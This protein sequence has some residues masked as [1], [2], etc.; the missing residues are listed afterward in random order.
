MNLNRYRYYECYRELCINDVECT[1]EYDQ[2]ATLNKFVAACATTQLANP[3]SSIWKP[4][5][6]QHGMKRF[7]LIGTR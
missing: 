4:E 7:S 1:Y 2:R 6:G 3:A 5:T